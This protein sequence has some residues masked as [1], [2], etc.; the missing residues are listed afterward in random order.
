MLPYWLIFLV[1]ATMSLARVRVQGQI[2]ALFGAI[3]ILMIGLRYRV[4]GDWGA[5]R[6]QVS[7]HGHYALSDIILGG[8]EPG[9]RLLNWLSYQIGADV[10]LVNVACATIFTIGLFTFVRSLRE[11][12]LG[13]TVSVPY[14]VV[15]V[16]MGY[17]RQAAAIGL[18]LLG[19]KY[20]NR[21]RLIYFLIFVFL[22]ATFHRTALMFAAISVL[23]V[24]RRSIWS[25][26]WIGLSAYGMYLLFLAEQQDRLWSAYVESDYA[27]KSEG[28]VIRVAMSA[29]AAAFFLSLG[30][31]FK[32]A[33][34][35]YALWFW[36]SVLSLVFLPLAY[37]A[38]TAVDR[39]ALYLLPIQLMV[40]SYLP[41]VFVARQAGLI[42]FS[43]VSLYTLVIFVWLFFAGNRSSWLP[44]QF[45]PVSY[46]S[47]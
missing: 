26:L 30:H 12:L 17:T 13:L 4:G 28:G 21:E 8:R 32:L 31:R 35:V 14:L 40:S 20:Y 15:I 27:H 42:R 47:G 25:F 41:G 45:W 22:A 6:R 2:W 9:Y 10:W 46:F 44:Y 38:P 5:Y 34:H 37:Q 16:S 36:I 39:M 43:I 7:E 33:P 19:L 3:M 1:P 24:M 23:A 18:I 29:M 11:P